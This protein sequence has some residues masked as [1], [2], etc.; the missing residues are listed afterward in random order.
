MKNKSLLGLAAITGIFAIATSGCNKLLDKMPVTQIVTKIDSSSISAADAEN[1][2]S[3]V[4]TAETGYDYGLE[5]NVLDRI[6]NGDVR[7]D[8]CYAGGD[9]PDNIA[10]DLFN[11]NALNGNI[12]R[13]WKDAYGIIGRIN[14]AIAQVENCT[15]PAL[16]ATRKRQIL[17]E[18]RF[19]RA[20]TYFDLVRLFGSIPIMLKPVDQTNSETLIQSTLVPQSSVDSVYLAILNDLW[21]AR[22]NVQEDN[23]P[24]TKMVVTKGAVNSILAKVYATM[25]TRQWDSV[26]YYCDQV[27]PDYALVPD[28]TYLWDNNHK[29]N[30]EAIWEFNYV[31]YS[32]VGNWIPSQFIGSG[33][34]K[35]ETPT[36]DLVKAFQDAN[37]DVRLNASISF[38]DYG[39]DDSYWKDKTHYPIL[40]KY[41]DPSNGTNDFYPIRLADILLLR[42][43]A[44]NQSGDVQNAAKLVNEVRARVKLPPTTAATQDAMTTAIG[45]ERRLEL[46]FEGHRWFYLVR[47]GQAISVMNAEKDGNGN[48]LN[49]DVQ[50]YQLVYPIPQTQLDLNPLLKQNEGY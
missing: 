4:Y 20:F 40:S 19:M 27:I 3:G 33:W 32:L 13:D 16:S 49:Y 10:I 2:L 5:F 12:A 23:V 22:D 50:P 39:W 43:E 28:Y 7:S 17:G 48:N 36:N 46:A 44:Y 6:T 38:I 8:N 41:N 1:L 14:I 34:K 31:G 25:P 11:Y 21:Y 24:A 30:S 47:T 35:F 9:N 42:A 45:N 18:A 37:D 26:A 15:D 29:N